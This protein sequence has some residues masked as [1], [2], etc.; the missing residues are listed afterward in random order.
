MKA[1]LRK[2]FYELGTSLRSVWLILIVFT[3]VS[4]LS[5]NSSMFAA[6][7]AI[8]PPS[9][10]TSI[11]TLEER[12]GWTATA[13]F[14]PVTRRQTVLEKYLFSLCMTLAG[15]I[16]IVIVFFSYRLRGVDV[17]SMVDIFFQFMAM[18]MFVAAILLPF[19]YKFGPEKG[20]YFYMAFLILIVLLMMG[21]MQVSEQPALITEKGIALVAFLAAAVLFAASAMISI[22]I[23]E[24]KEIT[25]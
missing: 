11:L 8:L 25:A 23:Y 16:V 3:A 12:T 7:L 20:R 21:R 1:I 5:E 4:F 10:A 17:G 15:S 6:Y 22:R 13:G 19:T 2:D 24:K 9:L 18:G 14:L